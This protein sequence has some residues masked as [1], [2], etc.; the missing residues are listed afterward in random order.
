MRKMYIED[1]KYRIKYVSEYNAFLV[2]REVVVAV[3]QF[4]SK[5][6]LVIYCPIY[7]H[8]STVI[9][10]RQTVCSICRR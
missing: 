2:V 8:I 4:A 6:S 5:H 7:H 10:A 1:R 3:H 9:N